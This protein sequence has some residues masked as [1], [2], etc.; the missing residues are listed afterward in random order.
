MTFYKHINGQFFGLLYIQDAKDPKGGAKP[1]TEPTYWFQRAQIKFHGRVPVGFEL[2]KLAW[3]Q[4]LPEALVVRFLEVFNGRPGEFPA[5]TPIS[6]DVP[7]TEADAKAPER[8][9]RPTPKA[10]KG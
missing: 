4:P 6:A 9:Q 1:S 10:E 8:P 2:D 5:D 3:P 7:Q